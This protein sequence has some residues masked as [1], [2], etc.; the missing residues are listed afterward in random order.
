[1]N[2]RIQELQELTGRTDTEDI[3]SLTISYLTAYTRGW[4]KSRNDRDLT[5]NATDAERHGYEDHQLG[6]NEWHTARE[7]EIEV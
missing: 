3:A 4:V 6:N 7:H 2:Y 5:S 1:M